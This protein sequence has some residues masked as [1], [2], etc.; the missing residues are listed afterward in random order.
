MAELDDIEL[1]RAYVLESSDAAFGTLV[2][3]HI[4]LV[5]STALRKVGNH[6]QAEEIT[7]A[8]FLILARKARSLGPKTIL[9]GW[10]FRTACFTASNYSRTEFRRIRREQ[11]VYMQSNSR[12]ENEDVWQQ[13]A[14]FLNDAIASLG[15]KD[16]NAIV[17]K[18]LD[19]KGFKEV[20]AALGASEDAAQMRVHRALEKLRKLFAKRGVTLTLSVLGGMIATQGVQAAP[21]G[22]AASITMVSVKTAAVT[23]STSNLITTTLKIMAW[24]KMKTTVAI[25][26]V[27]ILVTGTATTVVLTRRGASYSLH[28]P[29]GG[30]FGKMNKKAAIMEQVRLMQEVS[31]ALRAYAQAHNDEVPKSVAEL[32][33]YLPRELATIDD[34]HWEI[35]ATGK[36]T[37]LM[38][39][40]DLSNV[41]VVQLKNVPVESAKIIVYADGSIR[42]RN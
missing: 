11:E 5:Y 2:S 17:L 23:A 39:R 8:V 34:A 10:L 12:D 21:S 18:F 36:M 22:L 37:N 32:R 33:Q 19:G 40:P 41:A 27:A 13:V 3:R 25:A 16:R 7:Q 26:A 29:S 1:L 38:A 28:A 30:W 31:P 15:E 35:L 14:P 4:N 20:A 6:H 9:P 24:T 42:Y